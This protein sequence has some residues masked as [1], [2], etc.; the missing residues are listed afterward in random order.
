MLTKKRKGF[1][2]QSLSIIFSFLNE[3]DVLAELIRRVRLSVKPEIGKT[4]SSYRMIFINDASTDN[5]LDIL[6]SEKAN[7]NDLTILTTSRRFG[8]SRCVLAG[9]A[10]TKTDLIVYMDADLQDPPELIP[11][12]IKAQISEKTE[13]VH[14]QRFK[15]VG[16]SPVKKIWNR[17]G[18][19][20]LTRVTGGMI[21]PE[22]GDFKLISRK[23]ATYLCATKD[24]N[25]FLRGLVQSIGFRQT[26]IQYEREVRFSG[27]TK[28]PLFGPRVIANFLDSALISFSTAP[29]KWALFLGFATSFFSF[30]YLLAVVAMKFAGISIPGWSAIMATILFLGGIQLFTIGI[31]GLYVGSIHEQIKDRPRVIIDRVID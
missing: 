3:E 15:R 28:F 29:L 21:I 22:V 24:S 30:I 31:L 12:L 14:T 9:I 11:R 20:I 25:P 26:T 16:E 5:S 13:V 17:M 10:H 8:V 27:D 6:L 1:R 4:I 2:L 19:A 18:Y 7:H 23:V